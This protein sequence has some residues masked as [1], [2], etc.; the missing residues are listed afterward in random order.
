[1]KSVGV[2]LSEPVFGHGQLN[3][4]VSR[5]GS[6]ERVKFAIKPVEE[7]SHNFT[8][9]VVYR[10]V[11]LDATGQ[12]PMEVQQT[13]F[14]DAV[15]IKIDPF[16]PSDNDYEGPHDEIWTESD[17]EDRFVF[18]EPHP[19]QRRKPATIRSASPPKCLAPMDETVP[20][21]QTLSSAANES[22]IASLPDPPTE[23]L[24]EEEKER[25]AML[26]RRSQYFEKMFSTL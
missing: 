21:K 26:Q 24:T 8:S 20:R 22:W 4:A 7:D 6:R 15:A 5:V 19:V 23:E 9:N 10:E 13:D 16:N 1:M 25:E 12:T 18:K 3:V 11:L 14:R 2:W 17:L